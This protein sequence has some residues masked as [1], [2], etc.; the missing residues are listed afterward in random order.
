MRQNWF[1]VIIKALISLLLPFGIIHA[2]SEDVTWIEEIRVRTQPRREKEVSDLLLETAASVTRN[3]QVQSAW[4]YSHHSAP[5]G[6][7]LILIW[8]TEAVPVQGSE[9]A[10]LI[11]EGLKPLGLLDHMVLIPRGKSK[12]TGKVRKT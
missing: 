4:V 5:G 12:R 3:G 1:V 10:M 9:P 2:L 11:L 8:E 7:T 6:F